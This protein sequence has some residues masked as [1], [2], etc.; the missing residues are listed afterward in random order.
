MPITRTRCLAV[1]ERFHSL[2]QDGGGNQRRP[3]EPLFIN[4]LNFVTYH[5]F[6][7]YPRPNRD[8]GGDP[9]VYIEGPDFYGKVLLLGGEQ[10]EVVWRAKDGSAWE[11]LT[12]NE[13]SL[14]VAE[15]LRRVGISCRVGSWRPETR[16]PTT[17]H[18]R[19]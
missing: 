13:R 4:A 9:L 10:M 1:T 12:G 2:F 18:S 5:E 3:Y 7:Y 14:D 16:P 6:E 19:Y 15:L 17:P 8:A 11:A